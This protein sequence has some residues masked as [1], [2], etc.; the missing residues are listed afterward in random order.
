L[1]T[2]IVFERSLPILLK[3]FTN[4][5]PWGKACCLYSLYFIL[6]C[7][8]IWLSTQSAY[9]LIIWLWKIM[10]TYILHGCRE[11]NNFIDFCHFC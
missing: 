6:F 5:G 7:L 11:N 3:S 8:S 9:Y 4:T 10:F 2:I 1:S